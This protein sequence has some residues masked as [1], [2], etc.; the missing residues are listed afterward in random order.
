LT[1]I[2]LYIST[3]IQSF[4][5]IWFWLTWGF[6]FTCGNT[7]G[8]ILYSWIFTRSLIIFKIY[9]I[10]VINY[11]PN[12]QIHE[13]F[14]TTVTICAKLPRW[15]NCVTVFTNAMMS[16]LRFPT[17]IDLWTIMAAVT[18]NWSIRMTYRYDREICKSPIP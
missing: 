11:F 18:W 17:P 4:E 7:F 8:H 10:H 15:I 9:G 1:L 3:K 14:L 2:F 12:Q 5:K 6:F 13:N 16:C